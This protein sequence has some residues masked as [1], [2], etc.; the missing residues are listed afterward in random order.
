MMVPKN[1]VTGIS[2]ISH[3]NFNLPLSELGSCDWRIHHYRGNAP[4]EKWVTQLQSKEPRREPDYEDRPRGH[5]RVQMMLR[6]EN[7]PRRCSFTAC[8]HLL[9][10]KAIIAGDARRIKA[11]EASHTVLC[12]WV[13]AIEISIFICE[14]VIWAF[15]I[16]IKILI[17][18]ICQI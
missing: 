14:I 10:D 9:V 4:R 12:Y 17:C 16:K 8:Q 7:D 15:A 18:W 1:T 6:D 2:L 11:L 3:I 5:G 13:Y